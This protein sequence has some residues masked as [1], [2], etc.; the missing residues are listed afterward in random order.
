MIRVK[1]EPIERKPVTVAL[2]KS[3]TKVP[4]VTKVSAVT[5]TMGRPKVHES[6]ADRQRAYRERRKAK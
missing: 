4:A 6:G 1:G 3:V 5:K 2:R